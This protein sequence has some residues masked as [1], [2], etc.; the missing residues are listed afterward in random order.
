MRHYLI[1][2]EKFMAQSLMDKRQCVVDAKK[3]LNCLSLDIL[4]ETARVHRKYEPNIHDKHF[5]LENFGAV[6][7]SDSKQTHTR[8]QNT[9]QIDKSD[10]IDQKI[11]F[12]IKTQFYFIPALLKL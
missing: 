8:K 3:C 6:E 11:V 12:F 9:D 2:C 5:N 7:T 10:L 4:F 1:D